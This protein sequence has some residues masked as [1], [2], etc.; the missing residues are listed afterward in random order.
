[1]RP[2]KVFFFFSLSFD[3]LFAGYIQFT[4]WIHVTICHALYEAKR[5]TLAEGSESVGME[6]ALRVWCALGVGVGYRTF[7]RE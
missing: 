2:S 1:M 4:T 7:S 3:K 6:Q 5:K